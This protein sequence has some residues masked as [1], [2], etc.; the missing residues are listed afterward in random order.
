MWGTP[1]PVCLFRWSGCADL[2]RNGA[3]VT[4]G[5][6]GIG[7]ESVKQ[8]ASNGYEVV[9]G[10]RDPG[11][12]HEAAKKLRESTLDVSFVQLWTVRRTGLFSGL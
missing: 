12:G 9:L 8:L 6:R 4:G 10:S 5:N 2:K 1:T 11:K 7:Y 3:H